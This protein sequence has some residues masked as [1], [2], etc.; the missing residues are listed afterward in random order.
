L[1][2]KL[3]AKTVLK[4]KLVIFYSQ[5]KFAGLDSQKLKAKQISEKLD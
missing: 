3:W 4:R 5:I 1:L 2:K